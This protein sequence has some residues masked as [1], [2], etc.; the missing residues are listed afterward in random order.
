MI[1]QTAFCR[2][3]AP[4]RFITDALGRTLTICDRCDRRRRRVCVDC[5]RPVQRVNPKKPW[6]WRCEA[7]RAAKARASSERYNASHLHV[8]R[9]WSKRHRAARLA[10]ERKWRAKNPLKVAAMKR[11]GRLKGSWGYKDRDTYLAARARQRA[12]R[13]AA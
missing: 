7:H 11:A 9:R 4:L 6:P 10:S 1:E 8:R 12:E 3:R 13:K 5:E 2:C